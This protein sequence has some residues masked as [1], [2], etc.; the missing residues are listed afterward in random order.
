MD[1]T[2][3]WVDIFPLY[4]TLFLITKDWTVAGKSYYQI[5]LA[6]WSIPGRPAGCVFVAS[7]VIQMVRLFPEVS[8]QKRGYKWRRTTFPNPLPHQCCIIVQVDLQRRAELPLIAP[9]TSLTHPSYKENYSEK[10]EILSTE[11]FQ[12]D[13][14]TEDKAEEKDDTN[15]GQTCLRGLP[16]GTYEQEDEYS[17]L[18]AGSY[19]FFYPH[20][21]LC[22]SPIEECQK[23]GE[24]CQ[25]AG[26]ACKSAGE[27]CQS[28]SED[29]CHG[30]IGSRQEEYFGDGILY[31]E[32]PLE[33]G[34]G[35]EAGEE[36][37]DK[38]DSVEE[39]RSD[40]V[41]YFM[42]TSRHKLQ[43]FK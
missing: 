28:S 3:D 11:P 37:E 12:D 29:M 25:K 5:L 9:R 17:S 41:E 39:D 14:P 18:V 13:L 34:E 42:N 24:A 4:S 10:Q 8:V 22:Q 19:S 23:A 27:V 36:E 32:D 7:H 35:R 43:E 1:K 30:R 38:E 6:D 15:P 40:Y 26:E 31:I 33:E 16:T 20:P 2:E 21:D